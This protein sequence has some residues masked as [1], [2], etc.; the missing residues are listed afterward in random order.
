MTI[1]MDTRKLDKEGIRPAVPY[2]FGL[3]YTTFSADHHKSL[4]STAAW[5]MPAAM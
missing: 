5:Y 1:T 3:S 2:G 4:D